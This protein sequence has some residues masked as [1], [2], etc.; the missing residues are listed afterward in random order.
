MVRKATERKA[1]KGNVE[2]V[3]FREAEYQVGNAG[4][5]VHMLPNAKEQDIRLVPIP[6]LTEKLPGDRLIEFYR[7]LGWDGESVV[8]PMKVRLHQQDWQKLV[9][10]E[11]ERAKQLFPDCSPLEINL[12]V[13]FLWLNKGPSCCGTTLGM[14]ELLPDWCESGNEEVRSATTDDVEN[15][16]AD[17]ENFTEL[18]K[19]AAKES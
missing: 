11:V 13:G 4:V 15:F 9:E 12:G 16:V 2:A 6:T 1:E 5:Q 10:R 8:E 17:V 7:A 19:A 14:V 18:L 3:L